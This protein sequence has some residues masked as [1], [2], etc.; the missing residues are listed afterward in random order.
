MLAEEN[1]IFKEN[2]CKQNLFWFFSTSNG[3]MIFALLEKIIILYM[4]LT[5][6]DV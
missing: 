1:A 6:V 3:K 4:G 5:L 2:S